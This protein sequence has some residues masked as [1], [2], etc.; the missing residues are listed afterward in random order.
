MIPTMANLLGNNVHDLELTAVKDNTE[1]KKL[2]IATS[3]KAVIVIEDIHCSVEEE[4]E[5]RI[6][7]CIKWKKVR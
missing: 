7:S 5:Q 2:L 1:L 3:S 6:M 4:R